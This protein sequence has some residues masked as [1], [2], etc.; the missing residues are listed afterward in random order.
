MKKFVFLLGIVII[1]FCGCES[2]PEETGTFDYDAM[3]KKFGQ[4]QEEAPEEIEDTESFDDEFDSIYSV[5]KEYAED[6]IE[7]NVE[8]CISAFPEE[9]LQMIM[10][11]RACSREVARG[12]A[13]SKIEEHFHS[14]EREYREILEIW[15]DVTHRIRIED[16]KHFSQRATLKEI[17][18]GYGVKIQEAAVVEFTVEAGAKREMGE[19]RLVKL[20]SGNWALDMSFFEI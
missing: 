20:E 6:L 11:E 18:L 12:I 8:N 15:D 1:L 16:I 4:M 2:A 19:I 14:K 17:Y 7:K 3:D 5:I 13:I 9:F 10:E